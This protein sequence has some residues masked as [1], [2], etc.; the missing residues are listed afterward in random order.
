MAV[1]IPFDELQRLA[2]FAAS[3]YT[4]CEKAERSAHPAISDALLERCAQ[5]MANLLRDDVMRGDLRLAAETLVDP[6][7]RCCC[8]IRFLAQVEQYLDPE[9]VR[10]LQEL[11][12]QPAFDIHEA[13]REAGIDL[14]ELSENRN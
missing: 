9:E 12:E 4:G 8:G 1:V 14:D 5:F 13:L 7:T 6:V 3:L 11:W 2:E 10:E